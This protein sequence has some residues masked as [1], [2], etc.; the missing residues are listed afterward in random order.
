[1]REGTFWKLKL[2]LL[3]SHPTSIYPYRMIIAPKVCG[4]Q[5]QISDTLV[6]SYTYK[7]PLHL[8][9]LGFT[10][11][12]HH[13]GFLLFLN[14]RGWNLEVHNITLWIGRKFQKFFGHGNN[15]PPG[16]PLCIL[17]MLEHHNF[18]NCYAN[19]VFGPE[20]TLRTF[21]WVYYRRVVLDFEYHKLSY[22]SFK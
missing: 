11:F 1:M 8:W 16:P 10:R 14:H 17:V 4:C 13:H 19:M 3:P 21:N 5:I 22:N 9:I 7:L 20:H 15:Q 6:P 2:R 18:Y 12:H